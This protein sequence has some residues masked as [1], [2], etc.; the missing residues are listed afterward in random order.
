MLA[1]MLVGA[2]AF[3][4]GIVVFFKALKYLGIFTAIIFV[5]AFYLIGYTSA[6]FSGAFWFFGLWLLGEEHIYLTS[7]MSLLLFLFVFITLLRHSYT[8]VS[9][10]KTILNRKEVEILETK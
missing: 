1:Y 5:A 6:I 2:V 9:K 4:L 3:V 8:R 10:A 7:A